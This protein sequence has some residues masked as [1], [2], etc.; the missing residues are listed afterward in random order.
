MPSNDE[1]S[2]VPFDAQAMVEASVAEM[3][4]LHLKGDN[5]DREWW[6]EQWWPSV[7]S[8]TQFWANMQGLSRM[9]LGTMLAYIKGEWSVLPEEITMQFNHEFNNYAQQVTNGLDPETIQGLMRV[10]Q[11]FIIDDI[12][13]P[14]QLWVHARDA[15]GDPI[16]ERV[17][18]DMEFVLEEA[19]WN[20]YEI[21]Y[22]KLLIIRS[23]VMKNGPASVPLEAWRAIATGDSY[24]NIQKIMRTDPVTKKEAGFSH[25]WIGPTMMMRDIATG[26]DWPLFVAETSYG[27]GTPQYLSWLEKINGLARSLGADEFLDE[28]DTFNMIE[29]ENIS[30][31]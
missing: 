26:Q 31:N 4:E 21:P 27:P 29:H 12:G 19:E 6:I 5:M 16:I 11:T 15:D 10:A 20:P 1:L 17:D 7:N 14:Q 2:L 18:G 13:P 8:S 9:A 23:Q 22:S 3:R 24:A 25:Y 28:D 30:S